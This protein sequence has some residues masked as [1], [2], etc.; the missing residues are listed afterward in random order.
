MDKEE[1]EEYNKLSKEMDLCRLA[2]HNPGSQFDR[3][4]ELKHIFETEEL[5]E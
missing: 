2:N 3:Y 1:L 5:E 4:L